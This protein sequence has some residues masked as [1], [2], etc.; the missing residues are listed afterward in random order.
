MHCQIDHERAM[1]LY[2]Y[3]ILQ[4]I[5]TYLWVMGIYAVVSF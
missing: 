2:K 5:G 3:E 1:S 4:P